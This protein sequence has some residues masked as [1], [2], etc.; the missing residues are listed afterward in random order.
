MFIVIFFLLG[1]A[2]GYAA[3][4]PWAL[5][6]FV[7]PLALAIAASDRSVGAIVVGFIVTAVGIL[8]GLVLA[9]RSD[10]RTA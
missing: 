5:L 8:A 4:L 2:F 7:V 6:A 10:E 3:K 1:L 9:T